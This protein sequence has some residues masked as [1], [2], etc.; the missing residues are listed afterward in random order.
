[1][2]RRPRSAGWL[3]QALSRQARP[4]PH[5]EALIAEQNPARA[6]GIRPPRAKRRTPGTFSPDLPPLRGRGRFHPHH[7]KLL[8]P[9][10]IGRAAPRKFG[11]LAGWRRDLTGVTSEIEVAPLGRGPFHAG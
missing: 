3:R 5:E 11:F 1:M 10:K 8:T 7:A 4:P 2:S 9:S 6:G